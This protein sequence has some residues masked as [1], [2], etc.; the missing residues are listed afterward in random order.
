M[1]EAERRK[2]QIK[3]DSIK[4]ANEAEAMVAAQ[5]KEQQRKTD[6]INEAKIAAETAAKEKARLEQLAQQTE[7][8]KPQAGEKYKEV[9]GE[10]GLIPGYYLIANVFGTKKYFDAF[11]ADLTKKGLEPKSFF[12]S[13]DKYNYVYLERYDTLDEARKARDSKFNG[14]YA[15][16]MSIFRVKAE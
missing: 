7:K 6:S 8:D 15:D 10:D 16:K 2:N 4:K 14:R 12:R 1:T 3:L 11:M 5:R 13:K 9:V